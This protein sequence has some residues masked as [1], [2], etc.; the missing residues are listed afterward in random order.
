MKAF[1]ISGAVIV[2]LSVLAQVTADAIG[3]G[4]FIPGVIVGAVGANVVRHVRQRTDIERQAAAMFKE[5][6]GPGWVATWDGLPESARRIWRDKA[7][8]S[9]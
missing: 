1:L 8:K 5:S 7:R 9:A 3:L 2:P 4:H 6:C